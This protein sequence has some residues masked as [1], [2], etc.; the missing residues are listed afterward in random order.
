MPV[1]CSVMGH[2][3][4]NDCRRI[5][6]NEELAKTKYV[7]MLQNI[8]DHNLLH[9]LI[10]ST[11]ES[12]ALVKKMG[13][14][15]DGPW[16]G[17]GYIPWVAH[18][19]GGKLDFNDKMSLKNS[20]KELAEFYQKNLGH[21]KDVLFSYG[22]EQGA[23]FVVC[24]REF[25]KYFEEY[26]FRIGC[27]GHAALFYKGAYAYGFHPMGG[28]PD[29][30]ERIKRWSDMGDKYIGFYASQHTG[31]EN[32]A[33]IRRQNGMLGYMSGLNMI[34]NYEFATGPWNDLVT[35]E[36]KPMVVAYRN[37]GGLVNTLQ[38][39][40]FR[41]AVDDLRYAT[42]LQM[43]IQKCLETGNVFCRMEAGK[44]QMFFAVLDPARMDLDAV[45][46]EMVA[47][48]LKLQAARMS[49]TK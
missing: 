27:A 10:D 23:A 4:W 2:F 44:A 12:L 33:F 38:W 17:T 45:R 26:G 13:F 15:T 22:D 47:Y 43:E 37:Y 48:I 39:E 46:S 11:E 8:K 18:N 31:S 9:P 25:H 14:P 42:L 30:K 1:L 19:Y 6:Q 16:F 24:H 21:S 41:E 20:A 40:G 3:S 35:E 5:Y 29:A 32:P 34:F 28:E 7:E 36:Y 49:I